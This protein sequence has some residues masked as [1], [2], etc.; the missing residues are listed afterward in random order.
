MLEETAQDEEERLGRFDFIFELEF[1]R[2]RFRRPDELRRRVD[3]PW[4]APK[5]GSRA[6]QGAGRAVLLERGEIA[7]GVNPPVMENCE[8]RE[9]SAARSSSW[10]SREIRFEEHVQQNILPLPGGPAFPRATLRGEQPR[11]RVLGNEEFAIQA[12]ALLGSVFSQSRAMDSSWLLRMLWSPIVSAHC[13]AACGSDERMRSAKALTAASR[14]GLRPK[15]PSHGRCAWDRFA[16]SDSSSSQKRFP[17][18]AF[19]KRSRP[20]ARGLRIARRPIARSRPSQL[21]FCDSPKDAMI[22]G[23]F[24]R[25]G[26]R[27]GR[28]DVRENRER[29]LRIGQTFRPGKGGLR[30]ILRPI[31]AKGFRARF[32]RISPFAR[33][34]GKICGRLRIGIAPVRKIIGERVLARRPGG[35]FLR[36]S[37]R[38]LDIAVGELDRDRLGRFFLFF[39]RRARRRRNPPPRSARLGP[40]SRERHARSVALRPPAKPASMSA[41]RGIGLRPLPGDVIDRI[42]R[43]SDQRA[44]ER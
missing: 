23:G 38:A 20:S 18:F 24:A 6:D 41:P 43:A 10:H 37:H 30:I 29:A 11:F 32:A 19:R 7:E 17:S 35:K 42:D 33:L 44:V 21:R 3:F 36:P 39:A 31:A 14:D 2:E 34:Q 22:I 9:I 28:N 12:E 4:P 26:F 25:I 15:V 40:N 5:A 1:F 27:H 13:A 16:T 8:E